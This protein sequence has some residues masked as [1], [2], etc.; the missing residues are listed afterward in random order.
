MDLEA[1]E[2]QEAQEG[3][4][5]FLFKCEKT[6]QKHGFGKKFQIQSKSKL[7]SYL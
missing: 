1:Q 3:L 4:E 5:R 6:S 7:L 2:V